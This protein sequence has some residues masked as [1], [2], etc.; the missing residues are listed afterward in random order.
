MALIFSEPLLCFAASATKLKTPNMLPWSVIAMAF[1]PSETA[2]LNKLEIEA[3]PSNNENC[4]WQCKC[5][6]SGISVG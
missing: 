5:E 2:F 3:A 6:N 1:C 4:V